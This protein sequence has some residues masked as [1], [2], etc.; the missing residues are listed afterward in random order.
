MEDCCALTLS[1]AT[2]GPID[3]EIQPEV[4]SQPHHGAFV[5]P[6]KKK[7]SKK[8]AKVTEDEEI[9][10][11]STPALEP[12]KKKKRRERMKAAEEPASQETIQEWDYQTNG[13]DLTSSF[14]AIKTGLV[15]RPLRAGPF[16][17]KPYPSK[18]FPTESDDAASLA[19]GSVAFEEHQAGHENESDYDNQNSE[20]SAD[21]ES[22]P[23]YRFVA[24]EAS[25]PEEEHPNH[26][27][28]VSAHREARSRTPFIDDEASVDEDEELD[29]NSAFNADE[30]T[31]IGDPFNHHDEASGDENDHSLR[32]FDSETDA[33]GEDRS[34]RSFMDEEAS[35]NKVH[36][37]ARDEEVFGDENHDHD[38]ARDN[39]DE[40]SEASL[41]DELVAT[42]LKYQPSEGEEDDVL[43]DQEGPPTCS[44]FP[45]EDPDDEPEEPVHDAASLDL[46]ADDEDSVDRV[47]L[48]SDFDQLEDNDDEQPDDT[49]ED[50]D[51]HVITYHSSRSEI[52][53]QESGQEES[54]EGDDQAAE[55]EHGE[56]ERGRGV[57]NHGLSSY[58]VHE[59]EPIIPH[60][61][62]VY[63]KVNGERRMK[64]PIAKAQ[65]AWEQLQPNKPSADE[66][67]ESN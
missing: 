59:D 2:M 54:A 62:T 24:E 27:P 10:G 13:K 41:H 3:E 9:L 34:E 20:M 15:R 42:H 26:D 14:N 44:L 64:V 31:R 17:L 45:V 5:I 58:E 33:D 19:E 67:D 40:M 65:A 46:D 47:D 50:I 53:G 12:K 55:D 48:D 61:T 36:D 11:I 38:F 22:R 37:H 29:R 30:E 57:S 56:E 8:A 21:E 7:S 6:P 1:L 60:I 4:D 39:D 16:D 43:R 18:E 35:G 51:E 25:D 66:E 32:D 23:S 49:K 28:H 63:P 52:E